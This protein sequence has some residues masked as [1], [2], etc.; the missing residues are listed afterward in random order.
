MR[1]LN[2]Y[3]MK[4]HYSKSIAYNA[5]CIFS[6]PVIPVKV[7]RIYFNFSVKD[8]SFSL[9]LSPPLASAAIESSPFFI[10]TACIL[11]VKNI[12]I[13]YAWYMPFHLLRSSHALFS[14]IMLMKNYTVLLCCCCCCLVLGRVRAEHKFDNITQNRLK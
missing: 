2:H 6:D 5:M 7:I 8:A 13:F 11:P 1:L 14:E 3:G 4:N 9:S 10:F 12:N